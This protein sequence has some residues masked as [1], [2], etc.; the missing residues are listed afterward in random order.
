MNKNFHSDRLSA[1]GKKPTIF[2][3]HRAWLELVD[4]DGPF[5]AAPILAKVFNNG[6]GSVFTGGDTSYDAFKAGLTQFI[7]AWDYYDCLPL[8]SI[9]DETYQ[10]YA[11]ALDTWVRVLL[12]EILGW[13]SELKAY[14]LGTTPFAA[15]SPDNRVRVEA[16]FALWADDEEK[17]AV[18]IMTVPAVKSLRESPGDSW[19]ADYIDRMDVLL[20]THGIQLGLVTDGRWW[21][22]IS[23]DAGTMTAS[24]IFDALTWVE[25][26]ATRDAFLTLLTPRY[27]VGGKP[28]H[29]LAQ[30]F[31]DSV[32]AAEEVTEAL[33]AQVRRAAE[34]LI[35]AFS[36]ADIRSEAEGHGKVLPDT[37][38]VAYE[39][40]VTVMM[41]VVFLLFA[42]ERGLLPGGVLFE[43]GYG[44]AKELDTLKKRQ[45]S[46]SE[47]VLDATSMTWHRLLATSKALYNGSSFEDTRMPAYGGSLFD[48]QRFDFLGDIDSNGLLKLTVSDRVMLHVLSSVQIAVIKK[49][50]RRISFRDIDVEQ[51]G[52]IYEG[53]LGYTVTRV[54]ETTLGLGGQEGS[55]PEITLTQLEDIN[56]QI[57]AEKDPKG[58]AK[59]L[60][61][62]VSKDQ[63][64]AKPQTV[65]QIVKLLG[66]TPEPS[67]VSSLTQIMG[68]E[69][70]D[71]ERILP[72]LSIVR[73]DLRARPF[74][75]PPGGLLVKETPSRKNAGAHYTPK[76]LAEEVVLHALEPLCYT[77]GPYQTNN[78]DDF[79][80]KSSTEI[81]NLKVADIAC[82]SGAFLVAAA[83]YLADRVAEAWVLENPALIGQKNLPQRAIREVVAKCLY[84]ADINSM[85]VEMCKLSL[86]LVSLNPK[87]P[88]SFVDDKILTGNSL[89][90]VTDLK[91]IGRGHIDP[92]RVD[93][94]LFSFFEG[95]SQ[96]RRAIDMRR[97]LATEVNENDPARSTTAKKVKLRQ[98]REL[99]ADLQTMADGVIAAGLELGG[100]PGKKLD[101][102]YENLRIALKNA[103]EPDEGKQPEVSMLEAIIDRG[104]TPTVET[105]YERWKPLHWVLE[106]PDVMVD[107]GGFDAVIGNP[108]LLGSQ[109]LRSAMGANMRDWFVEQVGFGVKGIADLVAYFFLR[110][111]LLL[112][113]EG[114]LGLIATNTLSQG[115][116]R[117]VGLDQMLESGLT[118]TRAVQSKQW[119]AKSAKTKYAAVWGTLNILNQKIEKNCDE[120][121]GYNISS[122]LEIEGLSREKPIILKQNEDIAFIGINIAGKGFIVSPTDLSNII[123]S[124]YS[125][126]KIIKKYM[127]GDDLN[128]LPDPRTGEKNII[129]FYPLSEEKARKY[130]LPFQIVRNR[131]KPSRDSTSDKY[132]RNNWWR[133]ARD[134]GK[135]RESISSKS[136]IIA[137][138]MT[139]NTLAP[140]FVDS[141]NILDQSIVIFNLDTYADLS[142][143][144]SNI[145]LIW[146]QK[147]GSTQGNGTR[148]NPKAVFQNFPR[149]KPIK[150]ME[151]WGAT[152][153]AERREIMIRRQLGLTK[154]YNLVNN[155]DLEDSSDSDIAR[156][157][158]I[159]RELDQ[160]VAAAYGWQDIELDHGF[161]TYKQVTRYC[162]SPAARIEVLDRLLA[163]NHRRAEAEA[164]ITPVKTAKK[165]K[166][167]TPQTAQPKQ[168]ESLF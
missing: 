81:L 82:G 124:S 39:A 44:I 109:K 119:P 112:S 15:E 99:T 143:L 40:A 138:T 102:A 4:T 64:S 2:E 13:G 141:E 74:I 88:F 114:T 29:R 165:T 158:E 129:D 97:D 140:I 139:S 20:R 135:M 125:N 48:P 160:A 69:T 76:S 75:V 24:G 107:H 103:F 1:R 163:E 116:T 151:S 63:P 25:E 62:L 155:P 79:M 49:E 36:E 65:A 30:L 84:G 121:I 54:E 34:L 58:F 105:D 33:G 145:H 104:L 154:L 52:Y 89:L 42:E 94:A 72:W 133:F 118:I 7:S 68:K 147:Y 134:R 38:E 80:L 108:P 66:A 153:D 14:E 19:S 152:L 32:A 56:S 46:E 127:N 41:R 168:K 17:P 8:D 117:K 123:L 5:I 130:V 150:S 35:Q 67:A 3:Q 87:L 71:Y 157:R 98:Y 22:L 132:Y 137:I 18:L 11:Q 156:L 12:S 101:D 9:S 73:L 31:R 61:E 159:H 148:Y 110:A 27:V 70:S 57:S 92:S 100:K 78:R 164:K 60:R 161:Y 146:V 90:G 128:D 113:N 37:P 106:A 10:K 126:L 86:W 51:I 26:V 95:D 120:E 83:R 6:I 136:R 21:G 28:E 45:A 77:P 43:Q 23:A 167:S 149:P 131:V 50:A 55:E 53:L 144:C 96:I 91:Q 59:A 85:A 93:G 166:K 142:I 162:I 16:D 115:D 47:E 122:L 111:Q